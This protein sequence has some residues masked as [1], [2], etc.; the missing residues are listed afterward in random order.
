M[1]NS[2]IATVGI[3]A[4]ST[5]VSVS[6]V[7]AEN[8]PKQNQAAKLYHEGIALQKSGKILEALT[9]LRQASDLDPN[10]MTIRHA[11]IKLGKQKDF[12]LKEQKR[13]VL[14]KIIIPKVDFENASMQV[15]VNRLAS[16][17]REYNKQNGTKFIENFIISDKAKKFD[18]DKITL[19]LNNVPLSG[20]LKIIMDSANGKYSVGDYVI[21]VK[22]L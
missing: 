21:T 16:L 2:L 10:Q 12:L 9:K 14:D 18:D 19:S 3:V 17:V 6:T 15:V 22:P 4:L 8:T 11:Y 5:I 7:N 1:K 20:I 13:N